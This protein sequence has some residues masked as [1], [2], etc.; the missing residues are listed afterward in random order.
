MFCDRSGVGIFGWRY[1]GVV[2]SLDPRLMACIP[3][4]CFALE[5][6]LE[7]I[8]ECWQATLCPREAQTFQIIRISRDCDV[9]ERPI[10]LDGRRVV[11]GGA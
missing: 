1:P 10:S 2:A 7:Y 5:T 4:G 11:Y 3:P 9:E 6:P 8:A